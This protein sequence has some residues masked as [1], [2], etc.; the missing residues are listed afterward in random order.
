MA[1]DGYYAIFSRDKRGSILVRFP[2]HPNINTFGR[3]F[4][5]AKE[6]A[7]EALSTGLDADFERGFCLPAARKPRV[8]RGE[9]AVFIPLD[10]EVRTAY[11]LR[12]W[13]KRAGLSQKEIARKMGVTY[14]AYQRMERPG[15]S[16]LTVATLDRIAAALNRRLAIEMR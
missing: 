7:A 8:S 6:M 9:R 16:N 15:R 13:R 14:Q 10:P 2:E 5:H 1:A 12:E 3:D 11:L 4:E